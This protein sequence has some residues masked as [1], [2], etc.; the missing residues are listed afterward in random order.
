MHFCAREVANHDKMDLKKH[1]HTRLHGDKESGRKALQLR[2]PAQ[3][4][5]HHEI[6]DQHHSSSIYSKILG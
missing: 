6:D 3:A 5:S 2:Q 4:P 1:M